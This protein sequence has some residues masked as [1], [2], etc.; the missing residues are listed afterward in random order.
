MQSSKKNLRQRKAT[1]AETKQPENNVEK[2]G[3]QIAYLSA[4]LLFSLTFAFHDPLMAPTSNL[5]FL[6]SWFFNLQEDEQ[7]CATSS[8]FSFYTRQY[9]GAVVGFTACIGTVFSYEQHNDYMPAK[10]LVWMFVAFIGL[11]IHELRPY[12][13]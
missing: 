6:N 5:P 2:V 11:I 10:L 7:A 8:P 4:W 3:A 13:R 9:G 12:R 1:D